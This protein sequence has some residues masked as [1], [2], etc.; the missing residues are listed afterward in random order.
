MSSNR[1][2]NECNR[3]KSKDILALISAAQR[4]LEFGSD[5]GIVPCDPSYSFK[6]ECDSKKEDNC[7]MKKILM[8]IMMMMAKLN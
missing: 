4:V 8:M 1:F 2:C 6:Q 3:R 7:G 5:R